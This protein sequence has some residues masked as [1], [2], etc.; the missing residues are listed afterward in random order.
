MS[1]IKHLTVKGK[2]IRISEVQWFSSFKPR[3]ESLPKL[4]NWKILF[5]LNECASAASLSLVVIQPGLKP[6]WGFILV[7]RMFLSHSSAWLTCSDSIYQK[8]TVVWLSW[9]IMCISVR[10][11]HLTRLVNMA[12]NSGFF[13]KSQNVNLVGQWCSKEF[14]M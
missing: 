3:K 8:S 14:D 1:W 10:K 6:R 2:G 12:S 9:P 7:W 4:N 13:F 5:L 11:C